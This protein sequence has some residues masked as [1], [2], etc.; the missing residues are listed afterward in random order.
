MKQD[1]RL[2]RKLAADQIHANVYKELEKAQGL[3]YVYP[4]DRMGH[5]LKYTLQEWLIAHAIVPIKDEPT[6]V[7]IYYATEIKGS[8]AWELWHLQDYVVSTVSGGTIWLIPRF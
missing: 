2:T 3:K 6:I 8:I 1:S 7:A 4:T 5:E